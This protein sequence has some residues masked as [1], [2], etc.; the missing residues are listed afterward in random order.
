MASK[1]IVTNKTALQTKYGA[2]GLIQV[3]AALAPII[4]NDRSNGIIT[5]VIYLD[6]VV[7]MA[8][9]NA[10]PV[11]VPAD[12]K[13][14]KDAIDGVYNATTPTY[15]MILGAPDIIPHQKLNNPAGDR[16]KKVPSDLPYA[17][18]A[19]YSN[20]VNNFLAPTRMIGRLTGVTGD[21]S[22]T[23]LIRTMNNIIQ[24]RPAK[25]SKY[26]DYFAV[27]MEVKEATTE[28]V[29]NNSVGN[30]TALY[31]SPPDGPNWSMSDY[32]KLLSVVACHGGSNSPRWSGDD[33]N[34]KY[35][36]AMSS[37]LVQGN[38]PLGVIAGVQ[39]C[40]GAQLYN[41][42]AA[43]TDL[44]LCNQY[45]IGG[46]ALFF[47]ATTIGWSGRRGRIG[48]T[49]RLNQN[50][51]NEVLKGGT[52]GSMVLKTRQEYINGGVT[53]PSELKAIAQ[54]ISLGD[55]SISPVDTTKKMSAIDHENLQKQLFESGNQ[56]SEKVGYGVKSN[57]SIS[58][59]ISK[60]LQQLAHEAQLKE[61][62]IESYE[63]SGSRAFMEQYQKS[64][65][66][67]LFHVV[68]GIENKDPEGN[69]VV[70]V[71]I[72]ATERN[73]VIENVEYV[74]SDACIGREK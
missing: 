71:E 70:Y 12:D 66:S 24:I 56:L 48:P 4:A 69:F 58:S 31:T 29:L 17:C 28:K 13:Q 33:G 35:P 52:T 57:R 65:K 72:T 63:M 53:Q 25:V 74:Y 67:E 61:I 15:L 36:T 30:S 38:F 3:Q 20:T 10:P 43:G 6:D 19:A 41:P 37:A 8:H 23:N 9:Y 51:L 62:S 39:C 59:T 44:P 42:T 21:S 7:Q 1:I 16:D 5:T 45:T 54:F 2:G 50:Y 47:G 64:V 68:T 32:Q 22:P 27:C 46:A 73:G 14:N 49:D 11:T 55:P 18:E 34:K 60:E 40:Y 26:K